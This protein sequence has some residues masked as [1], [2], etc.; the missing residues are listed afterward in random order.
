MTVSVTVLF[1]CDGHGH[2]VPHFETELVMGPNSVLCSCFLILELILPCCDWSLDLG[3]LRLGFAVFPSRSFWAGAP[4]QETG[5]AFTEVSTGTH[6]ESCHI[7]SQRI[8]SDYLA[9]PESIYCKGHRLGS[10]RSIIR[11]AFGPLDWNI[12]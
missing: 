5:E 3:L 8:F 7:R 4:G 12:Y 6:Q 2:Y 1:L 9:Q 11:K 10:F